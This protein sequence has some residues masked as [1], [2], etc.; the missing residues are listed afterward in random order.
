MKELGGD[1]KI[2]EEKFRELLE[3]FSKVQKEVTRTHYTDRIMDIVKNVKKQKVEIDKVLLDT[4]TLQKEINS[5]TDTL[6]R[7]FGVTD[8]LIYQDA[9]KDAIAKELYKQVVGMNENFKKLAKLVEETGGTRN[10]NLNM[11]AKVEQLEE[12]T[13][14][15]NFKRIE[16]DLTEIK[17]ENKALTDKL[18]GLF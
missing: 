16:N 17:A 18:R 6:N 4:R 5:I 14:Q 13:N 12:R 3:I 7:T 8:E 1:V 10:Q 11:E 9:K 15:L 2:K